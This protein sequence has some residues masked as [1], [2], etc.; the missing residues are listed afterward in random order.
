[1]ADDIQQLLAE[2]AREL[3]QLA[4]AAR[5]AAEAEQE[6]TASKREGGKA[7]TEAG[8]AAQTASASGF[9]LAG[10]ANAML[11][12]AGALLGQGGAALGGGATAAGQ[13]V[14][15]AGA[16]ASGAAMG[17]AAGGPVGAAV[18]GGVAAISSIAQAGEVERSYESRLIRLSDP[19][20]N[21]VEAEF[22][23]RQLEI[24]RDPSTGVRNLAKG[25]QRPVGKLLGPLAGLVGGAV[26]SALGDDPQL[27]LDRDRVAGAPGAR[28]AA[29]LQAEVRSVTSLGG[30]VSDEFIAERGAFLLASEARAKE[31]D[32]RVTEFFN[33]RG[34]DRRGTQDR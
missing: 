32:E 14:G 19:G 26:E 28:A 23:R 8:R 15:G 25:L 22:Q 9:A 21:P 6:S 12:Q 16:I 27:A 5:L 7:A 18:G 13:V 2:A 30:Q 29:R 10:Q 20:I 11:G 24:E 31:G 33:R 1:M 34:G 4:R 3:T 17:F